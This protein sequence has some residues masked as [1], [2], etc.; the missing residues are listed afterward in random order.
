VGRFGFAP[1]VLAQLGSVYRLDP[2]GNLQWIGDVGP[3]GR[4]PSVASSFFGNLAGCL[5][6]AFPVSGDVVALSPTGDVKRFTGWS[7]VTGAFAV[8][9]LPMTLG[10][11]DASLFVALDSGRIVQFSQDQVARR[12]GSVLLTSLYASGSGLVTAENG[13]YPLHAWGRFLGAEVAA[14]F[15]QRPAITSV[16]VDFRP[17]EPNTLPWGSEDPIAVGLLSSPQLDA[18]IIDAASARFASAAA[19]PSGKSGMSQLVDLNGDDMMD[20]V[21]FF[22]PADMLVSPG[23]Q[24]LALEATTLDGHRLRG[25]T[26]VLVV[27]P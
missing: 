12:I 8:P 5:V 17:G 10:A 21:L 25:K 14:T 15:V 24:S 11:G 20:L 18:R 2:T 6:V 16:E 22:R 9:D 13:T 7:G 26:T 27:S 1:L 23:S 3:G 4:G 19:V